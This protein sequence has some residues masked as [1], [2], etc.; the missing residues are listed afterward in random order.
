ML[1]V[2]AIQTELI[3]ILNGTA[4]AESVTQETAFLR[5]CIKTV[6]GKES[7][8]VQARKVS[9]TAIAKLVQQKHPH[10]KHIPNLRKVKRF[11]NK[12]H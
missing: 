9:A 10:V 4:K 12:I 2:L 8:P 5:K 3:N 1:R 7:V 6:D 11:Q